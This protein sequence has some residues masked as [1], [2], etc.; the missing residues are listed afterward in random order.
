MEGFV[1]CGRHAAINIETSSAASAI[2]R[3]VTISFIVKLQAKLVCGTFVRENNLVLHSNAAIT[4]MCR[5]AGAAEIACAIKEIL[6]RESV[7]HYKILACDSTT[8]YSDSYL[9]KVSHER[10]AQARERYL[11]LVRRHDLICAPTDQ[12]SRS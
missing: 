12:G 1:E 2:I 8:I 5:T 4:K 3:R 10:I 9:R 6:F 11:F 7:H